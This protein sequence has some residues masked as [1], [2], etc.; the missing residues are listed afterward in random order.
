MKP[1][2][3]VTSLFK[4][5]RCK[6]SYIF[7]AL[8]IPAAL[9]SCN[10]NAEYVGNQ[11]AKKSDTALLD[12]YLE[13]RILPRFGP[14]SRNIYEKTEGEI[15]SRKLVRESKLQTIH[16]RK[17]ELGMTKNEVYMSWGRP[18][19]VN[20]NIGISYYTEQWVYGGYSAAG[21]GSFR[22]MSFVY[23]NSTGRVTNIQN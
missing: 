20:K 16:E 22:S 1:F 8:L 9:T 6:A 23:F 3:L 13:A 7:G 5:P 14:A 15:L 11:V 17:V 21:S 12:S 19:D 18:S 10:M 4:I 2:H